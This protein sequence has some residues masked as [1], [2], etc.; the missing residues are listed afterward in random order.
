MGKADKIIGDKAA[1]AK[2]KAAQ[3]NLARVVAEEV[4]KNGGKPISG[5]NPAYVAANRA[6]LAAEKAVPQLGR[7]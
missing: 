6:V 7:W 5:D 1:R 2:L 3:A 4:R